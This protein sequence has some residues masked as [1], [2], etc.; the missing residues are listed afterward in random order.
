MF[1]SDINHGIEFSE[2]S[3]VVLIDIFLDFG[4]PL[5]DQL[6][7]W[8]GRKR[9]SLCGTA[10]EDGP[11][12]RTRGRTALDDREGFSP[13]PKAARSFAASAKPELN[14]ADLRSIS[15][16]QPA[17]KESCVCGPRIPGYGIAPD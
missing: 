7:A 16:A 2:P 14:F 6:P 11:F 17:S 4:S 8:P 5:P 12:R 15:R 10:R 13:E 9:L 1:C 3:L